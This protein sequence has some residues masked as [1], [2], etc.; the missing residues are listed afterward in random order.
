MISACRSTSPFL[1]SE[2]DR[3]S[4]KESYDKAVYLV[5]TVNT[6]GTPVLQAHRVLCSLLSWGGGLTLMAVLTAAA[7][8]QR[9]GK[10]AHHDLVR[11]VG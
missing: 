11:V 9:A 3:T 8:A 4:G 5:E 10:V 6:E 7:A 1:H 2:L